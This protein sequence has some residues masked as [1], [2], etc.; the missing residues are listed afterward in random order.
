MFCVA[1]LV[2]AG[3]RVGWWRALTAGRAGLDSIVVGGVRGGWS[4]FGGAWRRWRDAGW[5]RR[6]VSAGVGEQGRGSALAGL[7][8]RRSLI[9]VGTHVGK[10]NEMGRDAVRDLRVWQREAAGAQEQAL[11]AAARA[12]RRIEVLDEQRVAALESLS[13]ALDEL[14]ATGVGRDQAAAFLGV[15][16]AALSARRAS[17]RG[18]AGANDPETRP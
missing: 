1:R 11:R 9:R 15:D 7:V 13:V 16:V 3:T 6:E 8:D 18:T 14:A 4:R 12:H 2:V 10:V 17:R 5:A